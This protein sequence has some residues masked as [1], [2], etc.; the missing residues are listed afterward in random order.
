MSPRSR[1]ALIVGL[2]AATSGCSTLGGN[3]SGDFACRAPSG[4]CAPMSDIDDR[5]IRSLTSPGENSSGRPG[6]QPHRI[7][8]ARPGATPVRTGERTLTIIFPAYVDAAGV[9]HDEARAHAV[10]ERPGWALAPLD[11]SIQPVSEISRS[12]APSSLREAIAGASPPAIEG[13]ESP[14]AQ[15]PHLSDSTASRPG[16][17]YPTPEALSAARRGHRITRPGTANAAPGT[18][19]AAAGPARGASGAAPAKR[20]RAAQRVRQMARPALDETRGRKD[21]PDLGS[22]FAPAR[23]QPEQPK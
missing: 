9:L 3:V 20:D 22:V 18:P 23:P 6:E 10:V 21:D 14:P 7:A 16:S 1:N 8:S 5:A 15:A 4:S 19:A 12:S 17:T 13:L 2:L 11:D